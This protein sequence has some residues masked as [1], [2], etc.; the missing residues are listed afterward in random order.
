MSGEEDERCRPWESGELL[1][2]RLGG[3]SFKSSPP[4]LCMPPSLPSVMLTSSPA[5][6]ASRRCCWRR[7]CCCSMIFFSWSATACCSCSTKSPMSWTRGEEQCR[8]KVWIL[9]RTATEARRVLFT[10]AERK[11]LRVPGLL[12]LH[13]LRQQHQALPDSLCYHTN[14]H[15]KLPFQ[16]NMQQFHTV[17]LRFAC[18]TQH[19]RQWLLWLNMQS[20]QT[21]ICLAHSA[22]TQ[23]L[24]R[25]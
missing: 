23:G 9:C 16:V 17:A 19:Y 1:L 4:A 11:S 12:S 21:K 22:V 18:F 5:L 3:E 2:G 15:F 6:A 14:C 25:G 7:T 8:M 20:E 10:E 13:T 24:C